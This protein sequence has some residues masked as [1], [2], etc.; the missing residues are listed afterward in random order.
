MR[1]DRG[2]VVWGGGVPPFWGGIVPLPRKFF[3]SKWR[4]FVH[5]QPQPENVLLNK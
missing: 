5:E 2:G 1:E 3:I 4:A